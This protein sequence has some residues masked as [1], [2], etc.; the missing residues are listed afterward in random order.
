MPSGGQPGGLFPSYEVGTS[1][2]VA[3]QGISTD[4]APIRGCSPASA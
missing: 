2:D 4:I 1:V 3:G